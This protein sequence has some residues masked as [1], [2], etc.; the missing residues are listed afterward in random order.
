MKRVRRILFNGLTAASALLCVAT[1]ALWVRSYAARDNYTQCR[2]YDHVH[3][4][5]AETRTLSYN[6]L[7][8]L[9]TGANGANS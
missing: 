1:I 3:A 6:N 5:V 8:A 2:R 7:L 4:F 9:T